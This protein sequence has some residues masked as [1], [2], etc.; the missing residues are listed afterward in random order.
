MNKK[1]MEIAINQIVIL[2]IGIVIFGLGLTLVY[3]VISGGDTQ[4]SAANDQINAQ[5]ERSLD[6]DNVV[7]IPHKN[8]N[9]QAGDL[10]T[11]YLGIFND[12]S[13]TKYDYTNFWVLVTP[14]DS[15]SRDAVQVHLDLSDNGNLCGVNS[16]CTEIELAEND[17]DSVV[18]AVKPSLASL[19]RGTYVYNV[20]VC[21]GELCSSSDP[22]DTGGKKI[23]CDSANVGDMKNLYGFTTI[24][25]NVR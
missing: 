15:T 21:E 6:S 3:K 11:F 4:L 16:I 19:G 14:Q 23:D 12:P 9:M 20:C 8:R 7:D 1:G 17:I 10:E 18:L 24:S 5:F 2:I 13:A 25:I 22:P